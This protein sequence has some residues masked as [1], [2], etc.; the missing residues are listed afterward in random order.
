MFKTIL[1]QI[2]MKHQSLF[3]ETPVDFQHCLRLKE[4]VGSDPGAPSST[5]DSSLRERS[6]NGGATGRDG[7]KLERELGELRES[8]TVSFP[9]VEGILRNAGLGVEALDEE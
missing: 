2:S 7:E 3:Q 9:E 8:S 4:V 6:L 5:G 1:V